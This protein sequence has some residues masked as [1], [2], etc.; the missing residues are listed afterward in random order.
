MRQKFLSILLALLMVF[1]M[2]PVTA[3]ANSQ[4]N[5]FTD[6]P[7]NW[8]TEALTKAVENGLLSGYNN[9][10]HPD[11]NLTRAEMATVINRAFGAKESADISGYTDVKGT[12]WFYGEMS[13]AVGMGTFQGYA[14]QLRPNDP[15]TRDE[16][17]SVLSNA[18]K[19]RAE[20]ANKVFIDSNE[21]SAWA[22]ESVNG[23]ING[24]YISG[25]N[26]KLNPKA[27]I[28]RAEFAQV[29]HNII[30]DY[31]NTATVHESVNAGN[32][33]VN[34]PNATLKNVT[35][36]GDLIIADGVGEGEVTLDNV[37][38]EGRMLVRAGGEN[39][40][41]IKGDSEID[42]I[43]IVK[44]GNKVRIFNETG[45]EIAVA[46][47]EGTADVILVGKFKNVIVQ[48][49]NITVYAQDTEIE[50]VEI[51]GTRSKVIVDDKSE[52]EKVV[53]KASNVVIEGKGTITEV[54]VKSGGSG[55]EITTPQTQINVDRGANNVVGTGGVEIEPN[56]TYVNGKT[57]SQDAKPLVQPSTG[58]S[59][60]G[61][62]GGTVTS[63]T[64][65]YSVVGSNGTLTGTVTSGNSVNIGT[66]V[67]FTATPS[68]GYEI[69][70]WKVNGVVTEVSGNTL[71][72]TVSEAT[73]VTVE[74]KE[75]VV[76]PTMYTVTYS[77]IGTGGTLTASVPNGGQAH[78]GSSV[79]FTATPDEG[80]RLKEWTV[81]GEVIDWLTGLR[82]SRD[83]NMDVDF[84]VE[85]ELI[86]PAPTMHIVTYSVIGT[87]GT[88]EASVS[89]GSSVENETEVIFTATPSDG[90]KIKE[91]KLNNSFVPV[92]GNSFG[93]DIVTA[94]IVTVEFEPLVST[95][96]YSVD[97]GA[98]GQGGI[99]STASFGQMVEEGTEVFFR[100]TPLAGCRLK[101]WR[102]NGVRQEFVDL[103][104]TKAITENIYVLAV[105][106]PIPSEPY[107]LTYS[108][109]GGNGT[110]TGSSSNYVIVTSGMKV[111][112]GTPVTLTAV[113][114]EGY[115]V[116][117]WRF[118][119]NEG[120]G[121]TENFSVIFYT[122]NI[123]VSVEFEQIPTMYT[124]TYSAGMGG[125]VISDIPSESEVTEGTGVSFTAI[126]IEGNRVKVWSVNAVETENTGLEF[127]HSVFVD[128]HIYVE[129]EPIP[130][131]TYSLTYSVIGEGG[132]LTGEIPSGTQA[133]SG[134]TV[135]LT[136]TPSRDYRVKSWTV[137][138]AIINDF[139]AEEYTAEMYRDVNVIV[140]FE[141][142]PVVTH[143]ILIFV[144]N[145]DGATVVVKDSED[146]VIIETKI[147]GK[148][149][150][151]DLEAGSYTYKVS[152][153]GYYTV[154]GTLEVT[155]PDV[156]YVTM[157][158]IPTYAVN[159]STN[160][161]ALGTASIFVDDINLGTSATIAKGTRVF[162]E[163]TPSAGAT[164]KEWRLNGSII[165]GM[166]GTT[167]TS[168]INGNLNI[169]IIL[170]APTPLN[171]AP[172]A[173][174]D[175]A[176]TTINM[177]V[178][179]NVLANDS[180]AENDTLSITTEFTSTEYGDVTRVETGLLYTPIPMFVGV[181][182]FQYDI[183][184]GKGGTA[185][186]TV[187]VTVT[188]LGMR[189]GTGSYGV[190]DFSFWADNGYFLAVLDNKPNTL[191]FVID[192][193]YH[194]IIGIVEMSDNVTIIYMSEGKV[195][196]AE[197]YVDGT[198]I[199]KNGAWTIQSNGGGSLSEIQYVKD[200]SD[201]LHFVYRDSM[202]QSS[203]YEMPDL[204]YYNTEDDIKQVLHFGYR[205]HY[206]G[207]DYYNSY[208]HEIPHALT[209]DNDDNVVV[210]YGYRD[211]N[212]WSG[213]QNHGYVLKLKN[214]INN[215]EL[216]LENYGTSSSSM[217]FD[218]LELTGGTNITV[219]YTYQSVPYTRVF[220][221][222]TLT[223]Q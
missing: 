103:E 65:N 182:E 140:E 214:I 159:V 164:V 55:T 149:Y 52:I 222:A 3:L 205:E 51:N 83:M 57:E 138:G 156:E 212:S 21:V 84:K 14:N 144:E 118:N 49:P 151:Y 107:T 30:K 116:K 206:G 132:T 77:V 68:N 170:E 166:T 117:E 165:D 12:D 176:T 32:V 172:V 119:G 91:W 168:T 169:E 90:Y 211:W 158:P 188:P 24:G 177:P 185:S 10:L 136:A 193:A 129:F 46:T 186:A 25:S 180:D 41:I 207:S 100:A 1:N 213:G 203:M 112:E 110:I 126:P 67:T 183:S 113:P 61:S 93:A 8:S 163:V 160:N 86:N 150:F 161:N 199:S 187:T 89:S 145:V 115:R 200:S 2:F 217:R 146:T 7:T 197:I 135:R 75:I 215:E 63:Y 26:G 162:I 23:M 174:N 218:N 223:E 123:S 58:G 66:S 127:Y 220:S 22:Q 137:N 198:N 201:V 216:V 142:I 45:K 19:L 194:S 125:V 42:T 96:K 13:K 121:N 133:T 82:V 181:D 94:T 37:K 72:R 29:M 131:T 4:A 43:V 6:M 35:I 155:E 108:V 20:K 195:K 80:Y 148:N 152:K 70:E 208:V 73:T 48:S 11:N 54:E 173:V 202:G 191:P 111:S 192:L 157:V 53:V 99:S 81:N 105:F 153:D 104:F 39:S 167:A 221:G 106:E 74:F 87:G 47:V 60:G 38:V 56:E 79:D 95:I 62:S 196:I 130:P 16:V 178:H 18:L 69:K 33:I 34:T 40:I 92:V 175:T 134:S 128:S 28:T 97:F 64:V 101:E 184:D 76:E 59:S 122:S 27:N 171:T 88:L 120:Y 210:M 114:D 209:I 190:H 17:F 50:N 98:E 189:V 204:M 143:E 31:V 124:V 44:Q 71:T 109:I 139:T 5:D 15:I 141:A 154:E 78:A 9:R 36:K 147:Q 85:F 179:I 102:I 219:N